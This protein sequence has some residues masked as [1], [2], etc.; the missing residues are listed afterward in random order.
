[1]RLA[2]GENGDQN[3]G[4]RHLLAAR[5]LHVERRALNNPL[6]AIG[7]LGFLLTVDNQVFEFGVEVLNDGLTQRVEIDAA[8]PQ[9][10]RRIDVVDQRQQQ[11]FERGVFM[12][13]LVGE[14]QRSTKGLFERAGEN[15]HRAPFTSFPLCTA[16]GADSCVRDPSLA[17]LLSRRSRRRRRRIRRPRCDAP[18]A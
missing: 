7:R 1:M 11:M 2:L 10:S 6:E 13:A 16:R 18:E 9:D 14:R 4:A 3:V 5:G 8:R 17:T 15:W 12:M